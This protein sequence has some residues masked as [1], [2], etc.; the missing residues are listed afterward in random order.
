MDITVEILKKHTDKRGS[1]MEFLTAKDVKKLG[2]YG[3]MFIATFD[4]PGK[5]RGNHYHEKQHEYY[6][7]I[8]GTIKVV[9]FD[10]KTKKRK[11]ITMSADDRKFKKLRI[12]PLIAHAAY[13]ITPTAVLLSYFKYPYDVKKPDAVFHEVLK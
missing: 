1:I 7:I 6:A 5:I 8:S 10:M 13:N 11:T 3:H 9:L 4:S 12:G 2:G